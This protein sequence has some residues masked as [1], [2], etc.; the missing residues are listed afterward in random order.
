MRRLPLERG[1]ADFAMRVAIR[2]YLPIHGL[3]QRA[4][5]RSRSSVLRVTTGRLCC[6]LVATIRP[7]MTGNGWPRASDSPAIAPQR[8]ATPESIANNRPRNR[9]ASSRRT[10]C[11]SVTRLGDWGSL[12]IPFSSSPIVMTLRNS[13][14][15]SRSRTQLTTDAFGLGRTSSETTQVS[16]S[17]LTT[18]QLDSPARITAAREIERNGAQRRFAKEIDKGALGLAGEASVLVRSDHHDC[19]VTSQGN[20]LRALVR[21]FPH[22][23]GQ[24]IFCLL[25]LP[26]GQDD[27]RWF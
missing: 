6:K 12:A 25:K 2:R 27:S 10:H 24:S 17:Q 1:L 13:S 7:S 26:L 18:S 3:K 9:S 19:V 22:N 14:P 4:P 11:S 5:Q 20:D 16:R 23:L 15:S 8:A 21:S